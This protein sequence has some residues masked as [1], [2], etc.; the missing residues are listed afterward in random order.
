MAKPEFRKGSAR[1]AGSSSLPGRFAGLGEV[2]GSPFSQAQILHLIKTE[3][4]RARRYEHPIACILI[5]VDR[6]TALVDVH[7]RQLREV[8]PQ[9][10]HA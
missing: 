10:R 6:L 7:G 4:S 9:P 2:A 3:F 8:P 1:G 5:Q